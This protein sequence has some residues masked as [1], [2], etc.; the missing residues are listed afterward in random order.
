MVSL[1]VAPIIED[2]VNWSQHEIPF[3]EISPNTYSANVFKLEDQYTNG[4]LY[5]IFSNFENNTGSIIVSFD[6]GYSVLASEHP[7][8]CDFFAHCSNIESVQE[9][10]P[11]YSSF[12]ELI[13]KKEYQ[14]ID[15]ILKYVKPSNLSDVLLVGLPRL[16]LNSKEYLK[17]WDLLLD[18]IG[19][20]I[21]RRGYNKNTLL[22]GL[23]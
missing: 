16:T 7:W 18:Q 13:F 14:T 22:S 4:Q 8:V 15:Q 9:L 21:Q 19:D 5:S 23:Y 10:L 17:N 2:N 11:F 20:E 6:E 3:R 12:N 1:D